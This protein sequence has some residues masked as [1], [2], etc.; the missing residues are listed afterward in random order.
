MNKQQILLLVV[1][2]VVALFGWYLYRGR[3]GSP[4]THYSASPTATP[5]S[6]ITPVHT[7]TPSNPLGSVK[8]NIFND[9]KFNPFK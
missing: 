1:V 7:P 9:V 6:S 5:L 3:S 8:T 2:I 4:A